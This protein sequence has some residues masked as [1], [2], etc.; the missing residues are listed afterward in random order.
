MCVHCQHNVTCAMR[1]WCPIAHIDH[2]SPLEFPVAQRLEHP[3]SVRTVVGSN[4]IYELSF[5]LSSSLH[6]SFYFHESHSNTF[7]QE[8]YDAR[9]SVEL[10]WFKILEQPRS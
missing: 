5:F 1:S 7:T 6:T 8:G 2:C 3:T 10:D 9:S 4:P